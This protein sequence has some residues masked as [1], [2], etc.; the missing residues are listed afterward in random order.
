[1]TPSFHLH[2]NRGCGVRVGQ[3]SGVCPS[4]NGWGWYYTSF[5]LPTNHP[6]GWRDITEKEDCARC[7]G[8]G[9]LP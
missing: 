9:S 6:T 5:T 8:S 4:C 7:E 3:D 2:K 1:M